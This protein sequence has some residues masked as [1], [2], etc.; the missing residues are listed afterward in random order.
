MCVFP[1]VVLPY[2]PKDADRTTRMLFPSVSGMKERMM[3]RSFHYIDSYTRGKG[4]TWHGPGPWAGLLSSLYL[5][6]CLPM[7]LIR[8]ARCLINF[9]HPVFL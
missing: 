8:R 1:T 2:L 4:A 3:M 6:V 7:L 9:C 5:F